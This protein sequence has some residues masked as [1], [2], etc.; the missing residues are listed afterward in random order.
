LLPYKI[1]NFRRNI[2]QINRRKKKRKKK[3]EEILC[4]HN[5]KVFTHHFDTF[6]LLCLVFMI[7]LEEGI[8]FFVLEKAKAKTTTAKRLFC[9]S[10]P[11]RMKK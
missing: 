11:K 9:V 8:V 1:Y 6:K 10:F 3:K 5:K 4:K 2:E 7:F